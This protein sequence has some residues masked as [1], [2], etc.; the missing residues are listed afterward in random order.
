MAETIS[1]RLRRLITRG[2][3]I[4]PAAGVTI[5][6]GEAGAAKL[7]IFSQVA[8]SLQLSFAVIPLIMFTGSR[9]KMGVLVAPRWLTVVVVLI[10]SVIVILNVKLVSDFAL[11]AF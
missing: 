4:V 5:F 9:K 8:L 11:S 1:T 3:A 6:A 7:L 10:A 2:I